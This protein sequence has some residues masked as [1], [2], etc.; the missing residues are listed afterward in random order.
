M[1]GVLLPFCFG[2]VQSDGDVMY[3]T[4]FASIIFAAIFL[5]RYLRLYLQNRRWLIAPVLMGMA[6]AS[7]LGWPIY[8]QIIDRDSAS[9]LGLAALLASFLSVVAGAILVWF[10]N[11][12][13]RQ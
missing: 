13:P 1:I 2:M 10:E 4:W 5:Y 7:L 6:M 8:E 9:F 12:T 11:V 3:L